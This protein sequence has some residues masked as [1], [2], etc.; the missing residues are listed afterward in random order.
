M[1]EELSLRLTNLHEPSNLALLKDDLKALV[2]KLAGIIKSQME[3]IVAAEERLPINQPF[4]DI[5]M[6]KIHHPFL[7]NPV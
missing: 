7:Q 4:D 1:S 5:D 3:F 6:G 2:L